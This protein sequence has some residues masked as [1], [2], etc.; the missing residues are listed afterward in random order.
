MSSDLI[1]FSVGFALGILGMIAV[2]LTLSK[3]D[4]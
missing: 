4:R 1:A 3:R 2:I